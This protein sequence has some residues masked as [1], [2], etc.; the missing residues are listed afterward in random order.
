MGCGTSRPPDQHTNN[1]VS[2]PRDVNLQSPSNANAAIQGRPVATQSNNP[3][4]TSPTPVE[5]QKTKNPQFSYSNNN[6]AKTF[7]EPNL[8]I[9]VAEDELKRFQVALKKFGGSKNFQDGEFPPTVNSLSVKG[10][11]RFQ[12]YEWKRSSIMYKN[13][14]YALFHNKTKPTDIAQGE[15]QDCY[16]VSAIS[17]LSEREHLIAQLFPE[18]EEGSDEINAVWINDGGEWKMVV[19]DDFFPVHKD[20]A[21]GGPVATTNKDVKES[22][23]AFSHTTG[24]EIW[25]N[26]IEKA[27]AK[28]FGS[29]EAIEFGYS[30]HALRDL[31]GAPYDYYTFDEAMKCWEYFHSLDFNQALVTAN[32]RDT[33]QG[34]QGLVSK[35]CYAVLS[36]KE[37][38]T[39]NGKVRLIKL[40]NPWGKNLWT[41]NWSADSPLWTPELKADMSVTD[42]KDGTFWI[43]V[44]DF[45]RNFGSGALCRLSDNYEY[46][47]L[48][49]T[50]TNKNFSLVSL[51][52]KKTS[53]VFVSVSQRDQRHFDPNQYHY[54][55]FK[56]MIVKVNENFEFERFIAGDFNK[57]RDCE[58]ETRLE[59]GEYL[60]YVEF[61]W[62]QRVHNQFVVSTYGE[63]KCNL[64]EVLYDG[65]RKSLVEDI[66]RAYFRTFED[67]SS[68]INYQQYNEP[69]ITRAMKFVFGYLGI[70]Y[71][72]NSQA[73]TLEEKV[74][75]YDMQY[76]RIWDDTFPSEQFSVKIPPKSEQLLLYC[77][78]PAGHGSY[79]Y[80]CRYWSLITPEY[81]EKTLKQI[82]V[83]KSQK[84]QQRSL[85]GKMFDIF[86]YN[87]PFEGGF[88][89]LYV[90][91]S[92][93]KY[94]ETLTMK[95]ENVGP[96]DGSDQDV[97][98]IT[99]KPAEDM[100]LSF[101][102]RDITAHYS[103]ETK[104][105][106]KLFNSKDKPNPGNGNPSGG[107]GQQQA[108]NNNPNP[109]GGANPS[110]SNAN[111]NSGSQAPASN[112]GYQ[113]SPGGSNSMPQNGYQAGANN[114]RADN[115]AYNQGAPNQQNYSQP[116]NGYQQP[117]QR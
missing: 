91:K 113:Q 21:T 14:E 39:V 24:P 56:I 82:I 94:V 13:A 104:V 12:K 90:N 33:V 1:N 102:V 111:Y 32:S 97:F 78:D 16:L 3:N 88:N 110:N 15:L 89:L 106:F 67:P 108:V 112:Q 76:L 8:L 40:R 22:K 87:Y 66:I 85:N 74:Q 43:S 52:V 93:F 38:N 18:L 48:R 34:D 7:F 70:L 55:L 6:N 101:K 49:L 2:Q 109:I 50:Q 30:A 73:S 37:A 96:A 27:Y 44:E 23:F 83:E 25:V 4:V 107:P 36:V 53:V 72:N 54:S 79:K 65:D 5:T 105:N 60:V 29:Y 68:Q 62:I 28:I 86:V 46:S 11:A 117:A 69:M 31:T 64:T 77:T 42:G 19:V 61:D 57:D 75:M 10:A 20:N 17:V 84:I 45:V 92:T 51:T 115:S 35:H 58:L 98:Y 41:G 116:S 114:Q 81:D 63:G 99:L 100:L 103:F 47:S 95:Y 80:K 9:H 59:P 26:L 71:R